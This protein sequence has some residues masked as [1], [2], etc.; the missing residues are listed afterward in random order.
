[1]TAIQDFTTL[2]VVFDQHVAL[3]TLNHP[4]VN[5]LDVALISDLNRFIDGVR[6]DDDVHVVVLQSADPDFFSARAD[7]NFMFDPGSLMALAQPD[8]DPTHNPLQQLNERF[9]ALPQTT[10]AKLRG[11]SR[12]GG[13][14]LAMAADMRFA[15]QGETW[16]AQPETRMGIFPGG[17]GTQ[18]L[19][20]LMSR[21]R[22]LE[23]VLGAELFDTDLAERYGWI[24]RA[25]PAHDLDAFVDGLARRIAA[26]PSAVRTAATEAVDAA[27]ASG[28]VP[29]LG[30]ESAAH[31]KVYPS[32]QAV[33]DRMRAAVDAGAQ[34]REGE[35][36]LEQL[37]D[38]V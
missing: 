25:V 29:N 17:G 1:M 28:P 34:T 20:R 36:D 30:E 15:A 22:V 6:D 7:M 13:A 16:L 14:E 12:A 26:L 37:L 10:I 18:Y 4:P 9:R 21:A 19:S 24:N 35:L 8:G 31:A 23:V 27:E 2:D 11:R 5:L 32:P 3:V 38:G 33:V